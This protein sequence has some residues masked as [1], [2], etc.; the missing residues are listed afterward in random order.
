MIGSSSRSRLLPT[1]TRRPCWYWVT[2]VICP[3]SAGDRLGGVLDQVEEHLDQPVAV[4]LDVRQRGVVELDEADLAGEAGGRDAAD[5]LQHLVDVDRP[6]L[7]AARVAEVLHAVDQRADPVRL[8]ADQLRSAPGP[9]PA[10]RS[11]GAGQHPG[12]PTSGCGPRAP[13]SR[14]G[15]R[16]SASRA[17]RR[18]AEVEPPRRPSRDAGRGGRGPAAPG[19]WRCGCRPDHLAAG[20]R[21]LQAILGYR[22]CLRLYLADQGE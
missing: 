3:P 16:P 11:R 13:A 21:K 9:P 19:S 22:R 4:A 17:G 8:V 14:R 6:A 7:E 12:C 15:R 10:R 2:T 1:A 18:A 20:Q 5:V